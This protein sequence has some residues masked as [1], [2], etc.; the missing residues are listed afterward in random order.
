[1]PSVNLGVMARSYSAEYASTSIAF[2][3]SVS[4]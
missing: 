4:G 2:S 1:M 3:V